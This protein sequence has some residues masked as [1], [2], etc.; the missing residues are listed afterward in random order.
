MF[1]RARPFSIATAPGGGGLELVVKSRRGKWTGSLYEVAQG[2]DG[3]G[4][5]PSGMGYGEKGEDVER[6]YE[7][8]REVR[9]IVEGP[10]STFSPP[11]LPLPHLSSPPHSRFLDV[12]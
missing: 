1:G 2:Q 3:R 10:Y 12:C 8:G 9:V 7:G 4:V 5:K 11:P 6:G